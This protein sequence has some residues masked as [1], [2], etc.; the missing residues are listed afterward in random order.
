[1]DFGGAQT[2]TAS[3]DPG[4]EASASFVY[5]DGSGGVGGGGGGAAKDTVIKSDVVSIQFVE[6]VQCD[7]HTCSRKHARTQVHTHTNVYSAHAKFNA[8]LCP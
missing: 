7:A 4:T 2:R 3:S 6:S 5:E 1:M 8:P